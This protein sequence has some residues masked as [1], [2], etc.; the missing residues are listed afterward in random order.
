MSSQMNQLDSKQALIRL[1]ENR[2]KIIKY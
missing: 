1:S 2:A